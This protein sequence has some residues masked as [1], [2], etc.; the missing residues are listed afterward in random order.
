MFCRGND[1]LS[2]QLVIYQTSKTLFE[3]VGS[4]AA[5][6]RRGKSEPTPRVTDLPGELFE[7]KSSKGEI[8]ITIAEQY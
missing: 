2:F 8:D 1:R 3:P 6:R 7:V 5:G 4:H